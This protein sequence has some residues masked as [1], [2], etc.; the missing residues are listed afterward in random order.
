[1]AC[2]PIYREAL[3]FLTLL[4]Q[5]R[6]L[7]AQAS[8]N[9][10]DI[11]PKL[12][13]ALH[14]C[15]QTWI[16]VRPMCLYLFHCLSVQVQFSIS[17]QHCAL[18]SWQFPQFARPS[19]EHPK[20]GQDSTDLRRIYN[21]FTTDLLWFTGIHWRT[22]PSKQSKWSKATIIIDKDLSTN[23]LCRFCSTIYTTN[24]KTNHDSSPLVTLVTFIC[25]YA[26]RY[27]GQVRHKRSWK[28]SLNLART[29]WIHVSQV[30]EDRTWPVMR[31]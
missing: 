27:S 26:P 18:S 12:H 7:Q 1:M 25:E 15:P 31:D 28:W 13:Y 19:S 16:W 17:S 23:H 6:N 20:A 8:A 24:H 14:A 10:S 29:N 30:N 2:M 21:G 5:V 9:A 4:A 3:P 22:E 11:I